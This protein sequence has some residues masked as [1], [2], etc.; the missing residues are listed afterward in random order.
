MSCYDEAN[1]AATQRLRRK[2][3]SE[4]LVFTGKKILLPLFTRMVLKLSEVREAEVLFRL[5][6]IGHPIEDRGVLRGTTEVDKL[7][8]PAQRQP[9]VAI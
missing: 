9:A 3:R 7:I 4:N 1:A 8:A 2:A 6:S 5:F